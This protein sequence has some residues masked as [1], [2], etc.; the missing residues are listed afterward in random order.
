[1]DHLVIHLLPS[2]EINQDQLLNEIPPA[3]MSQRLIGNH[4]DMT[5]RLWMVQMIFMLQST[6]LVAT[7]LLDQLQH[8][9][10]ECPQHPALV[11]SRGH[12]QVTHDSLISTTNWKKYRV[13]SN[14]MK[15][16]EL[17]QDHPILEEGGASTLLNIWTF[18]TATLVQEAIYPHL[19]EH[20]QVEYQEV[21]Q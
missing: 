15:M 17:S 4:G 12:P 1:M 16:K 5:P 19:D 14:M 13:T 2:E 7:P 21:P 3:W 20:P 11:Q 18:P 10:Q 8:H 6:I 9:C